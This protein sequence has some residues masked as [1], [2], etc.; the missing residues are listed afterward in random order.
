MPDSKVI[1][2]TSHEISDKI[3]IE[4]Q[5]LF[6]NDL[7][8]DEIHDLDD[9]LVLNDLLTPGEYELHT[10]N[11]NRFRIK[12]KTK[13]PS[14][15]SAVRFVPSGAKVTHFD[16]GAERRR[17]EDEA[18]VL[19]EDFTKKSKQQEEEELLGLLD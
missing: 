18:L 14:G 10:G 2:K 4:V 17:H 7:T 8:S 15:Q 11:K 13:K 12:A 1:V 3:K 6:N 5:R 16:K 9:M 19:G